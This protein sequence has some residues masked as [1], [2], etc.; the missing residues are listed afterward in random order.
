MPRRPH[1]SSRI[2]AKAA[3]ASLSV[4]ELTTGIRQWVRASEMSLRSPLTAQARRRAGDRLLWF[5]EHRGFAACAESEIIEFLAYIS[6]AHL[7]P[8]GRW[9]EV[10]RK[11]RWGQAATRGREPVKPSTVGWYYDHLR[12]LFNYLVKREILAES[13]MRHVER[14]HVPD[15]QVQ[16]F[17]TEQIESLLAEAK[18]GFCARRDTAIL[19][20]LL[21]T[22]CRSGELLSLT[23]GDLDLD[24]RSCRVV[25]KG[26]KVRRL[27]FEAE[28]EE[29]LWNLVSITK[30]EV[31][32]P[33]HTPLFR[34][35]YGPNAGKPMTREGL[36][37]V[38]KSLGE[39]AGIKG[40]RCSPHTMRHSM[41]VNWLRNGGDVITLQRILGHASLTVTRRY[42]AL[43]D[44][45][46]STAYRTASPVANILR[47][48][49]RR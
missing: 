43:A 32:L 28:T 41:A 35:L 26:G 13:P 49:P 36:Q 46:V 23:V 27:H 29:A 7:L 45:D 38:F 2:G 30:H 6:T 40:T 12:G 5:L 21:D 42:I 11:D 3:P 18:K 39:R 25:G 8:G 9:E 17:T 19:L 20:F 1:T 44:A 31:P 24:G 4:V 47:K 48:R 34:T 22:G 16:P 37:H 33:P 14:P 10:G 15:D